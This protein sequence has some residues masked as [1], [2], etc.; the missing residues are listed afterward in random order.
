MKNS[1]NRLR[2]A[3]YDT[4]DAKKL[5]TIRWGG[6]GVHIFTKLLSGK[7]SQLCLRRGRVP[8]PIQVPTDL[9][10][11]CPHVHLPGKIKPKCKK[12]KYKNVQIFKVEIQI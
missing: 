5:S 8:G 10:I 1:W 3:D 9:D 7:G 6:G 4:Y 2:K 11:E 12:N